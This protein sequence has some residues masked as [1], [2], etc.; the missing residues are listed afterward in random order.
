M[1]NVTLNSGFYFT[2]FTYYYFV[3]K[4]YWSFAGESAAVGQMQ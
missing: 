3:G 4:A 2:S 1:T